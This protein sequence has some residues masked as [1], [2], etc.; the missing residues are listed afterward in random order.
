MQSILGQTYRNW[1]ILVAGP[2]C[3]PDVVADRV[4]HVN[5]SSLCDVLAQARG[6]WLTAMAPDVVW[7]PQ[8][9][10]ALVRAAQGS[11]GSAACIELVS[12]ADNLQGVFQPQ[13]DQALAPPLWAACIARSHAVRS[14]E[15]CLESARFCDEALILRAHQRSPLTVLTSATVSI[16]AGRFE[17][18]PR[19]WR[20]FRQ[21]TPQTRIAFW[22]EPSFPEEVARELVDKGWR[23]VEESGAD[24]RLI[25]EPPSR[26]PRSRATTVCMLGEREPWDHLAAL[27]PCSLVLVA[28][29]SELLDL[30]CQAKAAPQPDPRQADHAE[31][32]EAIIAAVRKEWPPPP[33]LAAPTSSARP[34]SRPAS[35]L[36]LQAISRGAK[37]VFRS[38]AYL[39]LICPLTTPEATERADFAISSKPVLD[40]DADVVIIQRDALG[41][42]GAAENLLRQACR[43]GTRVV[44]DLD[45]ALTLIDPSHPDFG[46]YEPR[47]E[48]L[49]LLIREADQLWCA[50]AALKDLYESSA[51]EVHVVPNGLDPRLWSPPVP[52]SR[53]TGTTQLLYMGTATHDDDFALI[54]PALDALHAENPGGFELTIVGAVRAPPKRP[55]L[56]VLPPPA[57]A[58]TYPRFVRWLRRQGPF[59]HG[60]APLADTSFNRCKS[61]LKVLDYLALGLVPIVSDVGP[62]RSYRNNCDVRV[63]ANQQESWVD[64][65]RLSFDI[66]PKVEAELLHRQHSILR[67]RNAEATGRRITFICKAMVG[68]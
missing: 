33:E 13:L 68:A 65:L 38:S 18:P 6:R 32:A 17:T 37:G 30:I 41:H 39:R 36:R 57:G 52:E 22:A 10:E 11:A 62:Y 58:R 46:D 45:D 28:R 23:R 29:D 31:A 63:A 59:T 47:L 27:D 56:K 12:P 2:P 49:R 34:A 44:L 66:T 14:A 40:P 26:Q 48:A 64:A 8:H 50:T 16:P 54:L 20:R 9:L 7:K 60:L 21:T 3:V 67:T 61:D 25:A 4:R 35:R 19:P 55:W 43:Y 1:E 5:G 24:V 53:Q 15:T 51:R 42:R